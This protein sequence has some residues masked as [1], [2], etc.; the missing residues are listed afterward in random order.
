[1]QI[2]LEVVSG[3]AAP[4]T[5]SLESA[6]VASA[7]AEA[8][9]LGYTVLSG[10]AS[11]GAM[12]GRPALRIKDRLDVTVFV[13]QLRD[14]L[15][16]GLSVIESL[17]TLRRGSRGDIS[18]LLEGI[19]RRLRE[20]KSLSEALA[21]SAGFSELLVAL[22]R[23][24]ELTSDL[25]QTL[26]RYL[27][28]ERRVAEIRHR[29][30]SA[31]I[32]P[33]LLMAVGGAVLLFL[34]FY[35]MPR[36]ARIFEGMNG[37]LPWSARA[38]VGW[39]ALLRGNGQW[40][41]TAAVVLVAFGIVVATSPRWRAL[42]M[43]RVLALGPIG[44]RLRV[45][46]LARWYRATGMLVEGGIPLATSLGLAV[47]LLPVGMRA[48]GQA[49]EDGVR[50]GLSPSEAHGRAGLATPVAE[51]LLLAGERTGDLGA[52]LS[53]IAHFHEAEVSRSVEQAMRAIEPV[54]MILIGLGVGVVVVLMYM[55]IFELASAIK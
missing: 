54:V 39:S 7:R 12:L 13:E 28:H 52:V 31:A 32:Y 22:V 55:P 4:R 11:A 43:R 37:E 14:L 35:V 10:P 8:A 53:R 48:A 25:P 36:F 6:S 3:R 40:F 9:A 30:F 46:F 21:A 2:E 51:Q 42:T 44:S 33:L 50:Q 23:A 15:G 49:V 41:L 16:A 47:G 26:G 5:L 45:Y 19:E 34:L 20:G 1:M 27:D 38:M 29:L 18:V 24:S 17:D